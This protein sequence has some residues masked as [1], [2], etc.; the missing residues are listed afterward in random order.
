MVQ[1]FFYTK[2]SIDTTIIYKNDVVKLLAV[3]RPL[4]LS[5]T[6]KVKIQ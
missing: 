6:V 3:E 4:N 1:T 2:D 5:D